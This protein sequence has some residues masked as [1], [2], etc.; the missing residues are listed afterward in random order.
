MTDADTDSTDETHNDEI[1]VHD[2][3]AFQRDLLLVAIEFDGEKVPKGMALKRRVEDR[4][5]EPI[6]HGRLYTNLNEL[7]AAGLIKTESVDGRTNA[8]HPTDQA[9]KILEAYHESLSETLEGAYDG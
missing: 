3:L 9:Y 8:Y 7:K 5:T 6:N 2:L 1:T 4:Y